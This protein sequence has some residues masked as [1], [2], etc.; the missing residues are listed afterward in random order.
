MPSRW[1]AVPVLVAGLV[2]LAGC[3]KKGPAPTPTVSTTTPP[4]PNA[5]PAELKASAEASAKEFLTAAAA[6]QSVAA[7]LAPDFKKLVAEPI[8]AIASEAEK[9]QGYSDAVAD[10]WA[11]KLAA[12]KTFTPDADQTAVTA[13]VAVFRG[14][15]APDKVYT[16]RLSR[17]T[18]LWAVDWFA[19]TPKFAAALPT[20]SDEVAAQ[21]F[22]AAAFLDAVLD[23]SDIAAE[24]LVQPKARGDLAG[25]RFDADKV[26][27][28]SRSGLHDLFTSLRG[29]ATGY[30]LAKIEGTTVRGELTDPKGTRPVSVTLAKGAKPGEWAVVAFEAK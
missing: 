13:N 10:D 3:N 26:R 1:S 20:G 12:G 24:A 27:G 15:A 29:N 30:K 28:Y 2:A 19:V 16:L 7:K 22:A 23:K 17:D 4:S 11:K 25:P 14:A 21:R 6:G 8:P 5:S 9:K 18:G